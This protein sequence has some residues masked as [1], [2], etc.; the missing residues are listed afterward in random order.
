MMNIHL[1]ISISIFMIV[2]GPLYAFVAGRIFLHLCILHVMNIIICIGQYTIY[3]QQQLRGDSKLL[4]NR[5]VLYGF[6]L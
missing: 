6:V 4:K 1:I 5:H 2:F 3:Q